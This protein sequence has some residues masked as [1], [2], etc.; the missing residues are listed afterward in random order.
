MHARSRRMLPTHI[1]RYE[2]QRP[3]SKGGMASLYLAREP[4]SDHLVV[5]KLFK[6][7]YS[8]DQEFRGRFVLEAR[9]LVRLRHP[10]ILSVYQIGEHEGHPFLAME[11]IDGETLRHRLARTPP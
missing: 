1:G 7:E 11:Y 4:E 8:D 6:E 3:L 10:N 5:I 9:A 2:I